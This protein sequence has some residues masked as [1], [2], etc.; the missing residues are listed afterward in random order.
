MP[1]RS[2]RGWQ[3]HAVCH[4]VDLA[5]DIGAVHDTNN[6]YENNCSARTHSSFPRFHHPNALFSNYPYRP[7]PWCTHPSADR[8][9]DALDQSVYLVLNLYPLG[10]IISWMLRGY[11]TE[12]EAK[13]SDVTLAE[14]LL[15]LDATSLLQPFF[16]PC[17]LQPHDTQRSVPV[18]WRG[19]H[20]RLEQQW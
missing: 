10:D 7:L 20:L 1:D 13:S 5:V 16:T 8:L 12:C 15:L 2:T 18:V 11:T 6:T 9:S 14:C 17:H 19:V 4:Y 3:I